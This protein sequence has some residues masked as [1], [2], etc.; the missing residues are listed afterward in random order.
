M[1][2]KK[3]YQERFSPALLFQMHE[4]MEAPYALYLKKLRQ[5]TAEPVIDTLVKYR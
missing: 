2:G 1:Q 4:R 5:S 3:V